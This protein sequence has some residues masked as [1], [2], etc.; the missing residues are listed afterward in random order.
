M[1]RD[2][3]Y[4]DD[5]NN[6]FATTM[7]GS[8]STPLT[9]GTHIGGAGT[10]V[11]HTGIWID[12]HAIRDN[13]I[14]F[15]NGLGRDAN[16]NGMGYA[17]FAWIDANG[18]IFGQSAHFGGGPSATRTL[19]SAGLSIDASGN[20]TT[21][22]NTALQAFSAASGK[23]LGPLNVGASA[24]NVGGVAIGNNLVGQIDL[25][26][27]TL[28]ATSL[29]P[30]L[31]FHKGSGSATDAYDLGLQ[32]VGSALRIID[33]AGN[34]LAYFSAATGMQGTTIS[35]SNTNGVVA[36]LGNS[37]ALQLTGSGFDML[38]E[39]S[40]KGL[41]V[42]TTGGYNATFNSNGSTTFAGP[43]TMTAQDG[44]TASGSTQAGALALTMHLNR[45][46][47]WATGAGGSL[48]AGAQSGSSLE[49]VVLKRSASACLVYPPAGGTIESNAANAAVSVAANTDQIFRSLSPTA[50]YQ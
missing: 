27:S 42:H 48:P 28:P 39:I 11:M 5:I 19:P 37:L 46:T 7:I 40:G 36:N 50:W 13:A 1:A 31:R 14:L 49:F 34:Q 29:A 12:Q 8:G 17:G 20:L 45:I 32:D 43:V 38:N 9:G 24:A 16:G 2:S 41:A 3:A 30:A 4:L 35:T 44:I 15:A 23:V 25:G 47:A 22:A 33:G 10:G 6:K 26:S 21:T 18:G